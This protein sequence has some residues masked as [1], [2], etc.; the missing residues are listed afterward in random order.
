[1]RS[2][3]KDTHTRKTKILS[4]ALAVIMVFSQ[5]EGIA[6]ALPTEPEQQTSI[7]STDSS[8]GE[9][10]GSEPGE[11]SAPSDAA[12]GEPT[13]PD[14]GSPEPDGGRDPA[15]D[16][17]DTGSSEPGDGSNGSEPE[18]SSQPEPGEGPDSGAPSEPGTEPE[19]NGGPGDGSSS[20]EGEPEPNTEPENSQPDGANPNAA[21][22]D[23]GEPAPNA[24]DASADVVSTP[25]GGTIIE[26]QI[27]E[28]HAKI[29][30]NEW[31]TIKKGE[32]LQYA[33]ETLT[34]LWKVA[35]GGKFTSVM[36]EGSKDTVTLTE[37]GAF[38]F[39]GEQ[40][41]LSES[42]G[43]YTLEIV[44]PKTDL[45]IT[46]HG[47]S[48]T[49]PQK[50]TVNAKCNEWIVMEQE[51]GLTVEGGDA[52]AVWTIKKGGALSTVKISNST[53]SITL[54][55]TG[56]FEF[57]GQRCT[58]EQSGG[59]YTLKLHG[60][61]E[62][63]E[64]QILGETKIPP[65]KV[66]VSANEWIDMDM[67]TDMK[68]E[69]NTVVVTWS[70]VNG[71][72]FDSVAITNADGTLTLTKPEE[73][74]FLG[75]PCTLTL[76][77][78]VYTLRVN[79]LA[80]DTEIGILGSTSHKVHVNLGGNKWVNIDP[81]TGLT[82]ENGDVIAVWSI[83]EDAK[84]G[85]VVISN[86][87][88]TITITQPGPFEFLGQ[89]CTLEQ[90]DN[91]YTMRLTGLA[92]DT[93]IKVFGVPKAPTESIKINVTGDGWIEMDQDTGVMIDGSDVTATWSIRAGGKLASATLT[94]EG[95]KVTV[96]KPGS[97]EFQGQ[98]CT[99]EQS[100]SVYIMNLPGLTKDTEIA[101]AGEPEATSSIKVKVQGNS[102]LE[103]DPKTGVEVNGGDVTANWS[104]KNGGKLTSVTLTCDG[105]EVTITKPGEFTF[106][107]QTGRMEQ[108]DTGYTLYMTGLTKDIVIRILGEP[109]AG[110]SI[111]V[112][113][114][115]NGYLVMNPDTGLTVDGG[116][117]T[118]V[119]SIKAGGKLASVTLRCE[120]EEVTVNGP[121][122]FTFQGKTGRM[123]QRGNTYTMYLT[124]LTKDTEINILGDPLR[125]EI[126][127]NKWVAIDKDS[128]LTFEGGNLTA[129]WSIITDG[130]LESVVLKSGDEQVTLTEA[131][132]FTAFG[133]TGTLI[134][135]G[136]NWTL[137]L[138]GLIRDVSITVNGKSALP[139]TV[140]VTVNSR[141]EV[142][143]IE[144]GTFEK[145]RTYPGGANATVSFQFKEGVLLQ[146]FTISAGDEE[147]TVGP[148]EEEFVLGGQTYNIELSSG[149]TGRPVQIIHLGHLITDMV[150]TPNIKHTVSVVVNDPARF[151]LDQD[152]AIAEDYGSQTMNWTVADGSRITAMNITAG[153]VDVDIPPTSSGPFSVNGVSGNVAISGKHYTVTLD[154]IHVPIEITLTA[155]DDIVF[156]GYELSDNVS[157]LPFKPESGTSYNGD[158]GF[159]VSYETR[160]DGSVLITHTASQ[161]RY[162]G[163]R[164]RLISE[165]YYNGQVI[166]KLEAPITVTIKVQC[167]QGC[168]RIG[169]ASVTI[170][171]RKMT[172]EC[173]D[174][175]GNIIT[176]SNFNTACYAMDNRTY[177]FNPPSITW[178]EY[179]D[180][181]LVQHTGATAMKD[182]NGKVY[183][184]LDTN[185]SAKIVLRYR[186]RA[187]VGIQYQDDLGQ[188]VDFDG[189]ATGIDG[190]RDET[191][192]VS[193]P[194]DPWY[195]YITTQMK[196]PGSS[197]TL[198]SGNRDRA[199]VKLNHRNGS[200][201]LI[202]YIAK[203]KIQVKYVD[204]Q[205]NPLGDL[206]PAGT[207][208]EYSGHRGDVK[209]IPTP[210]VQN[211]QYI[212]MHSSTDGAIV[213]G[214]LNAQAKTV[215]LGF[216][217][218]TTIYVVYQPKA[219]VAVQYVDDR[220][221][222]IDVSGVPGA[223]DQLSGLRGEVQRVPTPEM[224]D[225][226]YERMYITTPEG[227]LESGVLNPE[228]RTVTFNKEYASMVTVVYR[229][230]A[231]FTIEYIDDHGNNINDLMPAGTP[232]SHSGHRDDVFDILTPAITD[233]DFI[234]M[235]ITHPETA[236]GPNESASLDAGTHKA[237]LKA[238]YNSVVKVHY[239]AK[240]SV[241]IQ[242]KDEL[243]NLIDFDG[244][245]TSTNGYRDAINTI[246]LP[247][248]PYYEFDRAEL[249]TT[250]QIPSGAITEQDADKLKVQMLIGDDST[251]TVYYKAKA[252]VA[253][254]Y[255][256]ELGNPIDGLMPEGTASMISGLRGQVFPVETPEMADYV[257][258][259]MSISTP[260]GK[261]VSGILDP[262][263]KQLT[264]GFENA[265]TVTVVYHA[266][267]SVNVR[268]VDD[269]GTPIDSLMPEG[270][271]TI[272]AG[273]RG[274][275]YTVATPVLQ[276][277]DFEQMF[278][279]TPEG[280]LE[281]G[282]LN[283]IT[284]DLELNKE[285]ASTVTLVYHAK[286]SFK[287]EYIDDLGQNINDVVIAESDR[288]LLPTEP[289]FEYT[290]HRGD[291]ITIQTP[292]LEDYQFNS[293]VV[294]SGSSVSLDPENHLAT[295]NAGYDG[296]IYVK[297]DY[298]AT[299]FLKYEDMNG[300]DISGLFDPANPTFLE[301]FRN[302]TTK[303]PHPDTGSYIFDHFEIETLPGEEPSGYLH[304]GQYDPTLTFGVREASTVTVVYS[305]IDLGIEMTGVTFGG[306]PMQEDQ[307]LYLSQGATYTWTVTNH[308]TAPCYPEVEFQFPDLIL[309]VNKT[310]DSTE[311][312][313]RIKLKHLLQPGESV[314]FITLFQVDTV[315]TY[316][317]VDIIAVIPEGQQD[318]NGN[319]YPDIDLSNNKA[320]GELE[321]LNPPIIMKKVNSEN[322]KER[323]EDCYI[324][325][326]DKHD[327]LVFE[328][329]SDEDGEWYVT[330]LYPG[331]YQVW[332]RYAPEG[333]ARTGKWHTLTVKDDMTPKG[334]VLYND[335]VK[336]T[337]KKVD[338]LNNNP[339][340]GA[341][342]GLYDED[343][344]LIDTQITNEDG[345]CFFS[346]L[347]PGEFTVEELEAPEGYVASGKIIRV[348]I[349]DKWI[350]RD[351]YIVRNAPAVNTG[352]DVIP[353]LT[354]PYGIGGFGAVGAAILLVIRSK[355]KKDDEK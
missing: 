318:V 161:A 282:F 289:P 229:A 80:K 142:L 104:I 33:N 127:G 27:D 256:D 302:R 44:K 260:D 124:G 354:S 211:Y 262:E 45:A 315:E 251:I 341:K 139:E 186:A 336:I 20:S 98:T 179:Q 76:V 293:M 129:Q 130:A 278:I 324:E 355:R 237:T 165:N 317:R 136:S 227:S 257:Y 340:A 25:E 23:S 1:M 113:V 64:L 266:K 92:K 3:R 185:D 112:S 97:F 28:Y 245:T 300:K 138:N 243:G 204:E 309:M 134:Q 189:A 137:G 351:P 344:K 7:S 190:Y 88:G 265:S 51:G 212:S 15:G 334:R 67:S 247:K 198:V 285:Y 5:F 296:V 196:A 218:A 53:D 276:D 347:K 267:A 337:I 215:T 307:T 153:T 18:N 132:E 288:E 180:A 50:I 314:D 59:T 275:H 11:G 69:G 149:P 152:V 320:Q 95:E 115:G 183:F 339:L 252:D 57:G 34:A 292:E 74:Q 291:E 119:W 270:S 66:S 87:D 219:S 199:S 131:G 303:I 35:D 274:E 258:E 68:V 121:G 108:N 231:S 117:V 2:G 128:A 311:N 281:S 79:G 71:G 86:E 305:W 75:K 304:G 56:D 261:T 313:N 175:K 147:V 101:L 148:G 283:D 99:L 140:T 207:P 294:Q 13:A 346:K 36:I 181:D 14:S 319:S 103:M 295:M 323:L 174:E 10:E 235:E 191:K 213:S 43:A 269:L 158:F 73:T 193:M 146:S 172:V 343:G 242:Y 240:G 248:H 280:S 197:G 297:Y 342:F 176:P 159:S 144:P 160:P 223:V 30:V 156:G 194:T 290:G 85:S 171:Y 233:Y 154:D 163:A 133:K 62:D 48:A 273:L 38:T 226:T 301:G 224:A 184:A 310:P 22:G 166:P 216:Q 89:P 58:L 100:G 333:F 54:L 239:H 264:M 321:I 187:H 236:A 143:V 90:K 32:S 173:Q 4:F 230:K 135:S 178:Y 203:A 77:D 232:F 21:P 169:T 268:Y 259:S 195:D 254:K 279:T 327:E 332:E 8:A 157:L 29:I 167:T 353:Y 331:E 94:C 40:C 206:I 116:N 192:T 93:V 145:V 109:I 326:Y 31:I 72:A 141:E 306:E 42:G 244:A 201:L 241:A 200:D 335:P 37:T 105:E 52:T 6:Y 60:L 84:L 39:A 234:S 123:E 325:I 348:E 214:T 155:A 63:T 308:G 9:N 188:P 170:P 287:V 125:A 322:T 202:K 46:V 19:N 164:A 110:E 263:N 114:K 316:E 78:G 55:S 65:V 246:T 17:S 16:G 253:I 96:T 118:A 298:R 255:V 83:Q 41:S 91:G 209:N 238:G 182:E 12:S 329:W 277:Y 225:Y 107:G 47:E 350:N 81:Q 151:I 249:D 26:E 210:D 49:P 222:P 111:R 162:H 70:I 120:D 126:K 284:Y 250:S 205:G 228:Q 299:V 286:A 345:L 349:T 272:I 221:T 312:G 82:Y 106:Q 24:G 338:V 102:W 61:T 122:G 150:V 217:D 177:E 168:D 271:A 352:A 330:D 208:G 328:G 220:G